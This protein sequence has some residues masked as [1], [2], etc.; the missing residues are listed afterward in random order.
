[1]TT[2]ATHEERDRPTIARQVSEP[3]VRIM[4][5]LEVV[6]LEGA[7]QLRRRKVRQ[8]FLM[9]LLHRDQLVTREALVDA[10]WPDAP[11][12][13]PIASV[14]SY[15]AMVRQAL[16]RGSDRP[17]LPRVVSRPSGYV[18]RVDEDAVDS[19]RLVGLVERADQL[20]ALGLHSR[21][22]DCTEIALS[23]AWGRPYEDASELPFARPE[24]ERLEALVIRARE[25]RLEVKLFLGVS[26]EVV[27]EIEE[28]LERHPYRESLWELYARSLALSGRRSQALAAID[29]VGRA[30]REQFGVS[31]GDPLV[32]L[33]TDIRAGRGLGSRGPCRIGGAAG[34][35][36][37][38]C[39]E[40][41]VPLA[42]GA[43]VGREG[44]LRSLTEVLRTRRL[45][46]V[47]GPPGVGKTRIAIEVADGATFPRIPVWCD[48]TGSDTASELIERIATSLGVPLPTGQSAL[49][50]VTEIVGLRRLLLVLDGC[51]RAAGSVGIVVE[52]LLSS[53]PSLSVLVTSR[54]PLH[55][56]GETLH[57]VEPLDAEGVTG[58][59]GPVHRAEAARGLVRLRCR[60]AGLRADLDTEQTI[61]ALAEGNPL[62]IE[63][64]AA[65]VTGG[66]TPAGKHNTLEP[67]VAG[68]VDALAELEGPFALDAALAALAQRGQRATGR[69]LGQL[70]SLVDGSLVRVDHVNGRSWYRLATPR[71][72]VSE[73]EGRG[74]PLTRPT[75][76]RPVA[77]RRHDGMP[78]RAPIARERSGADVD[79]SSLFVRAFGPL[80]LG[81]EGEELILAR[82]KARELFL[83]LLL[84]RN[85]T[86][87][88][89][90]IIDAL[91][92]DRAPQHPR[93]SVRSYASMIRQV[94]AGSD[95]ASGRP[96]LRCRDGSYSLELD[97]RRID[98][99]RFKGRA[100]QGRRA[101]A[102]A[103]PA[104]ALRTFERALSLVHGEPL[105]DALDR[106]FAV[107]ER[108]RIA[109]EYLECRENHAMALLELG[110]PEQATADLTLLSRQ[111]PHRERT[112]YLLVLGL[113]RTHRQVEAIEGAQALR[114]A[115]SD[116]LG[117]GPSKVF[118]DLETAVLSQD[119][120]LDGLSLRQL[121]V[122][123]HPDERATTPTV[124]LSRRVTDS[125]WPSGGVRSRPLFGRLEAER[126]LVALLRGL[127]DVTVVGPAG[128]GKSALAGHASASYGAETGAS[129]ARLDMSTLTEGEA[130]A[131]VL[132]C[133]QDA[134]CHEG[135]GGAA[136]LLLVLDNCE[137]LH[138][139]V[140]RI[141]VVIA[142]EHR[143]VHLLR[144]SRRRD[145]QHGVVYELDPLPGSRAEDGD[146]G[147]AVAAPA[148]ALF[149][150]A[151]RRT[152]RAFDPDLE[153]LRSVVRV[154]EM[155]DN[156]PLAV[157]LAAGTTL[158]VTVAELEA[159]LAADLGCVLD[160]GRNDGGPRHGSLHSAFMGAYDL[161]AP[162]ERSALARGGAVA[163]ALLARARPIGRWTSRL[164][165]RRGRGI[166]CV[167]LH[168]PH[169]REWRLGPRLDAEH[170][171]CLRP[172]ARWRR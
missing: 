91:W 24:V 102:E 61:A 3:T 19:A 143:S 80:V 128:C 60:E 137:P 74:Q 36:Q 165:S 110:H 38:A 69:P 54:R 133:L 139:A 169:R 58:E 108:A 124:R 125:S 8:L 22:L 53:C 33:A 28:L 162:C 149:C 152:R 141:A 88:I 119:T 134:R 136:D 142:R 166:P 45:V 117:T 101:L 40:G 84:N 37:L 118:L 7:Q 92:E 109:R 48:L 107:T 140:G 116:E 151:A 12:T 76:A 30:L 145:Q 83:L 97:E 115:M 10:L 79:G 87:G 39:A 114:K 14:R 55:I 93:H 46:T 86:M 131:E 2:I 4:G 25:L 98:L 154:C 112:A 170:L 96:R 89:N 129:V 67:D 9:L 65:Q 64:G 78:D 90:S 29:R 56:E 47:I 164:R 34:Q 159:A 144:T 43:F 103:L 26:G 85:E 94:L 62:A 68:F 66:D 42:P 16:L 111:Y 49:E 130:R 161:L 100:D 27:D 23:L 126:H 146:L 106:G 20:R 6:G 157:V 167:A 82:R 51:D 105:A 153:A 120:A 21:A 99:V 71:R 138:D 31:L 171:A 155:V 168:H 32:Q 123:Y 15:A 59:A 13:D 17:G 160:F 75:V 104:Q 81:L 52:Q 172:T 135:H 77:S 127:R 11:P 163:S 50:A 150:E 95:L 5:K 121:A 147:D 122:A 63:L 18:L 158:A 156:L 1:M 41:C 70:T 57:P 72:V 148:V 35:L 132:R 73:V 44:D 113:Y